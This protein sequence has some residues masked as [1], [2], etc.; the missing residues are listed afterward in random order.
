MVGQAKGDDE[1][2]AEARADLVYQEMI[3]SV[4]I[5]ALL[6]G[7][8]ALIAHAG[9][10]AAR[11][12]A[13]I[14]GVAEAL[15]AALGYAL[16]V[17]LAGFAISAALAMPLYRQLERMKARALWPF[18]ALALLAALLILAAAGAGPSGAEPWRLIHL[19]PG[20]VAS[21]L[22]VRKLR[23]IWSAADAL[24]AALGPPPPRRQ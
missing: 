13:S 6:A 19:A 5:A 22:F 12:A 21:V 16:M 4:V 3:F 15:V 8:G 9:P 2:S 11:G 14:P 18:P 23:A 17:F 24:E 10:M 1:A 7:V 20:A